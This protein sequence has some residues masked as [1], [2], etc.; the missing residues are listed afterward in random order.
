MGGG[1]GGILNS[2]NNNNNSYNLLNIKVIRLIL[3]TS[4]GVDSLITTTLQMGKLRLKERPSLGHTASKHRTWSPQ[5]QSP[6]CGRSRGHTIDITNQV[7]CH[8]YLKRTGGRGGLQ[9]AP[10]SPTILVLMSLPAALL[11]NL[12]MGRG[13][14]RPAKGVCLWGELPYRTGGSGEEVTQSSKAWSS[15]GNCP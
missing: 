3:T 11:G 10:I 15:S 13:T 14:C 6:C 2:N 5:F 9:P 4:F 8:H 12:V 7:A 1:R